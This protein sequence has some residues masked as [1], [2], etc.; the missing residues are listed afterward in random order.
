VTNKLALVVAVVLGILSIVGIRMYVDTIEKRHLID[1]NLIDVLVASKDI[2]AGKVFGADDLEL[3]QF[4]AEVMDRAFR[5]SVVTDRTTIIGVKTIESI[6]AGQVLQQ[7]H[8]QKI[9]RGP[10]LRFDK[11]WRAITI[12]VSRV[13]GLS[14]LLKPTDTVDVIANMEFMDQSSNSKLKVTRAM[15]RNVLVLAVDGNTDPFTELA[16]YATVTLRLHSDECNQL[17]YCMYNG[18]AL[19]L[20]YVQSGTPEPSTGD[21][22]TADKMWELVAP[23]VR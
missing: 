16:T 17:A 9:V 19:H 10:R 22:V 5:K 21:A 15:F 3:A 6:A 13:A 23:E 1:K 7:Y 12:P 4:P 2:P 18:A 8:F 14:G 11:E 20:T